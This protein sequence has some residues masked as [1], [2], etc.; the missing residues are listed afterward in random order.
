MKMPYRVS[1]L[2]LAAVL[3]C[4]PTAAGL[5]LRDQLALAEKDDDTQAQIEVIRRILD[6][7]L[8]DAELREKLIGLWL[9][10]EDYD[11]AES[12]VRDWKEAPESLRVSVLATV[13]F[14]R[15]RKKNEAIA[16]L[17]G[18]VGKHPEDLEATRQLAGYLDRVGEQKRI[19]ELLSK[20]PGVEGDA[21]LLVSRALARRKLQSFADALKDFTAA[22][23]ADPDDENVA[24][25]RPSFDRLRAALAGIDAAGAVLAEKPD[26]SAALISRA[27]WYL[28]TGFANEPAFQDAEAARRSDPKSVAA[29]ILFAEASNRTGRLSAR[30]AREKF[31]VD[32]SK[33]VSAL[34]VL[35]QIWR[36]DG[37]ISRNPKDISA[38]LE[39]S[40]ELSGN[41]Q[42]YQLALRDAEAALRVDTK[43]ASARAAKITALARL[44]RIDDAAAELRVMESSRPS[45]DELAESLSSLVDAAMSASQLDLA[46]EFSDRAI[47]AKPEARYYKQRA[48]ILQR[49]ERFA[50]AQD[51]LSRAQQLEKGGVQ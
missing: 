24:N 37:Q 45:H 21:S 25:N 20:A 6:Q 13:F 26:D 29:L 30:D 19:V 31:D 2:L 40:R 10:V 32:V 47:K 27:Y 8:G 35:D 9:S 41:A 12:T 33:P 43:N 48:A 4:C 44:G 7:E 39:R 42:Q 18:Y 15:D 51:D 36:H 49:F 5:S 11:M 22:E 17:E 46:L 3:A 38:L 28:S 23:K 16:L 1:L 50:E 34:I 14:V